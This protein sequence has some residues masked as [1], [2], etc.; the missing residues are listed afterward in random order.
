MASGFADKRGIAASAVL[1]ALAVAVAV[2]VAT[3]PPVEQLG[4][5]VRLVVFHGASTWVNLATF[6]FAGITALA[7][8]LS[9][10]ERL[11]A[12]ASGL[13][14][15]SMPLWVLNT[16][17][18]VLSARMAWGS[19]E[20]GEPRLRMTFWV[21]LGAG[22]VVAADLAFSR[23]RVTA[24]LDVGLAAALWF[25]IAVSPNVV[26]PDNPVLNSDWYI[27]GPFF[28]MVAA[29]M[30]IALISSWLLSRRA[31]AAAEGPA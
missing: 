22:L 24:A 23:P 2:L 21:L 5:L 17:L 9:G 30:A 3:L 12:W 6:T 19:V 25:G 1:A 16:A 15:F 13:R 27:K 4:R 14:W 28:V 7:F 26:H 20:W 10:G 29:I 8:L 31:G 11:Y 18:G